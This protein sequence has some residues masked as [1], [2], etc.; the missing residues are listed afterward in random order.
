M[1]RLKGSAVMEGRITNGREG[2][3]R[4]ESELPETVDVFETEILD[5]LDG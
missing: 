1:D 2:R 4:F 5:G 3:A